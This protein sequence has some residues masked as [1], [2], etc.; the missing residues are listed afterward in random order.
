MTEAP[1]TPPPTYELTTADGRVLKYC[2]YGPAD[3]YPVV[4]HNGT[5]GTRWLSRKQIEPVEASGVRLLLHDR[6]GYA[7]S[8][9]Q[10]GRRVADVAADVEALA[11]AQGWRTFATIGVSGGGPHALATAALLGDRVTACAA[12]VSPAPYDADGL[13]WYEGMSPGNVVEFHAAERGEREFRPLAERLGQEA[14]A[15]IEAGGIPMPDGYNL[16]ESDLEQLRERVATDDGGMVAR[17]RA[18]EVDGVDGWMDDCLAFIRPWGFDP[19][20]IEVPL[21]LWSGDDDVL[22]P[23]GHA[24]WLGAHLPDATVRTLP[25]GHMFTPETWRELYDWLRRSP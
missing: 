9:R 8:T 6:P 13:D 14:L 5:P 16:P 19:A 4:E 10:P 11:D 7:G 23:R 22:V 25:G 24:D 12:V 17:T 18:S 2:L 21:A 20:T 3:G 15:S 1:W